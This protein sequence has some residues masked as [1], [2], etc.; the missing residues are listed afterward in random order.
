MMR[1]EDWLVAFDWNG[2]AMLDVERATEAVNTVLD[3]HQLKPLTAA[4]FQNSFILP[5]SEW[6]ADLG[7]QTEDLTAAEARWNEGMRSP[8]HVREEL[9]AT[10]AALHAKGIRTAVVTAAELESIHFDLEQAGL[11][12]VFTDIRAS[13]AD[14]EEELKKFRAQSARV[15]YVGDTAY[16]VECAN[17]S[18]CTSVGITGGYQKAESLD[19]AQA[20]FIIED[21]T[22]VLDIV[23]SSSAPS[24]PF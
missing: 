2:T 23:A 21:L 20:D 24:V 6:L 14:K 13:V 10:L 19:A 4:E 9:P 7:V 8:A 1:A 15:L 18:F 3:E 22:E 12:E 17:A 5:M 11:K 16:D